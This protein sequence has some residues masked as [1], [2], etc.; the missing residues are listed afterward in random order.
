MKILNIFAHFDDA[1]IWGG[2]ALI[3]HAER[4]DEII[5]LVNDDQSSIKYKESLNA[6]KM[7]NG[8][9]IA[10]PGFTIEKLE[11]HISA[12]CPDVIL[13]HRPDDSNP[14]HRE[15]FEMVS[16]AILKPWIEKQSPKFLFVVDSYSSRGLGDM[17]DP[18]V[19]VDISDVWNKKID[20]IKQF[21][22]EPSEM[23]ISM[24]R[25]QN[26]F[27]GE[28]V[29]KPYCE[30]FKQIPIQGKLTSDEYLC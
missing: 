25:K 24:I 9:L 14:E 6:H 11:R 20:L 15:V 4:G 21:K 26:E 18:S 5:T 27:W 17:F 23:W 2:G 16:K 7:F 8:R 12:I 10:E 13:T 22:S 1:E 28:G 3:K 29:M 30:V 19:F